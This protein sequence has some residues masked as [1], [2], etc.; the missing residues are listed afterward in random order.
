MTHQTRPV[1]PE[2][3]IVAQQADSPRDGE[4]GLQRVAAV[5]AMEVDRRVLESLGGWVGSRSLRLT[6]VGRR[7]CPHQHAINGEVF[8]RK[9]LQTAGLSDH[10]VEKLARHGVPQ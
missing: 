3:D 6:P 2:H 9:Q 8:V 5:F 1:A 10:A 4:T 7:P